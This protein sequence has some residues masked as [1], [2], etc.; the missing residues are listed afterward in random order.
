MNRGVTDA[1]GTLV[2]PRRVICVIEHRH[3]DRGV[4][5]AACD[6][7]FTLAGVTCELGP[8][9]DWLGA[10]LP[11]DE[12]WRIEWT[13]FYFGLDLA[14]AF[15]AT[16]DRCYAVAWERLVGSYIRTV[17][18]GVD[19]SDVAARR[20]QNWIYAW[21]AFGDAGFTPAFHDELLAAVREHAEYIRDNL[22]AERNHRTLELYA[23]IVVALALPTVDRDGALL[24]LGMREIH[25]NLVADVRPDG[26]HREHS[27]DYHLIAL[28][29]FL[30]ARANLQ[31]FGHALPD[32][33]DAH[34]SRAC[35][36]AMHCHRPDGIIPATSD[37]DNGD[38]ADVLELGAQV[39][40]R[41]DL[42]YVARRGGGGSA[43]TR[44]L[45]SFPDGGYWT[46]RSGW[47]TTEA[48][49]DERFLIFDCGPVGDGGHGHY[50]ALSFEAMGKGHPLVVDPGRYTYEE[51]TPNMRHW[52]KGTAAHNTVAVDGLDQIPYRRGKP[53]A[54]TQSTARLVER[55]SAPGLD[56]LSGQVRSVAYEA[57]HDRQIV[58]VADSYWL[59]LD[60]LTGDEPHRYDLRYHLAA[61][62]A[63]AVRVESTEHGWLVRAPGA[64]LVVVGAIE[65]RIEPGWVAPSYG[66][67]YPAPVVSVCVD[68]V[69]S[70]RFVTLVTPDRDTDVAPRVAH[71][72]HDGGW[73]TVVAVGDTRDTI[74]WHR[75]EAPVGIGDVRGS[76]RAAWSRVRDEHVVA[77]SVAGTQRW[78]AWSP[79]TGSVSGRADAL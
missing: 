4:A 47:G 1:P 40:G 9:P 46:Q 2:R 16:G 29:S 44:R 64:A 73:T 22:T 62:A 58:F 61:S 5:D 63:G 49:A 54:G 15:R 38:Y 68:G 36:F 53:R 31:L 10:D 33:Y 45:M 59:I 26:V 20:V 70:T 41:R 11:S 50:D 28:R 42:Q 55:L 34:L 60:S 18:I 39:L 12:E 24:R 56:I 21:V 66:T 51:A 72:W 79:T 27:T 25:A 37:S 8:E 75:D 74:E 43:P 69:P 17:P 14:H 48:Y 7:R 32:D 23:L 6:G 19:S 65:P 3:R 71:D 57:V 77:A 52:F 76:G 78:R 30:G 35:D 67:K 13:K